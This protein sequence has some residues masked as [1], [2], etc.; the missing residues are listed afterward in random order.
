MH[1]KC[2]S[3]KINY[4]ISQKLVPCGTDGW[5]LEWLSSTRDLDLHL[6]SGHTAHGHASVNDLYLHTKFHWNWKNFFVD[7]LTAETPQGH[8]SQ[9]LGQ[10]SKIRPNEI[11][12]LCCS[13]RISHRPLSPYQISLKWEKL[14]V[15]GRMYWWTYLLTDISEPL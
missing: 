5:L 4:A 14:F 7:G 1:T 15:D 11:Y 8:V 9:K 2:I 6:G 10:I 13:L 12:I 3:N